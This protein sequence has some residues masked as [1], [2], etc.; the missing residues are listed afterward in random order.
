MAGQ[1]V[2]VFMQRVREALQKYEKS[3]QLDQYPLLT[4]AHEKTKQPRIYIALAVAT[5]LGLIL[6][7]VLGLSFISN[8]FAFVP[9]YA[10]F[11]ALRTIEKDDDE[12]WLTYWVVYGSLGLF[13]S[14]FDVIFFWMPF[15]YLAKIAFLVWAFAPQTRGASHIYRTLLAPLFN[16]GVVQVESV[17]EQMKNKKRTL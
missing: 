8:L 3:L 7:R 4:M 1:Q 16:L 12:F 15:Y 17:R 9:I 13:E 10:S 5:L 2:G 6:I 11:K 14:F